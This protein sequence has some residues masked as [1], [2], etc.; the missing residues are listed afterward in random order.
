MLFVDAKVR[1]RYKE[2]DQ[3]GIVH[4]SN[5]YV[6]FEIGRTEYMR[7][8]GLSYDEMERKGFMLPLTET[9]CKYIQG[10]IYDDIVII[11]TRM[12]TFSGARLTMEYQVIR[13][14][15]KCLLAEGKTVHGVTNKNL[16]PINIKKA[17]SE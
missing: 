11:R 10:A 15:D 13:E 5:Y 9:Y 12:T 7:S 4:H 6:W 8:Q 17:D 2:T 14:K 1:V 3:M 16:K